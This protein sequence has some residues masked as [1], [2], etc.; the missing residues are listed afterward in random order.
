VRIDP[1][2]LP[3]HSDATISLPFDEK[4]ILM[5]GQYCFLKTENRIR[6]LYVWK[7]AETFCFHQIGK[8]DA[9]R[10]KIWCPD[11]DPAGKDR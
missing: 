1:E 3:A 4:G 8:L 7:T 9:K 11:K 10:R 5:Q 2:I 6:P